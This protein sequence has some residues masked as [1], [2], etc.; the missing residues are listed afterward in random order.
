MLKCAQLLLG[1]DGTNIKAL[2]L[3]LRLKERRTK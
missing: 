3:A 1:E 2:S